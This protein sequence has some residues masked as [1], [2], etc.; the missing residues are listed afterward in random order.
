MDK[1]QEAAQSGWLAVWRDFWRKAERAALLTGLA[2]LAS[3]LVNT[4][5]FDV[6]G[7]NFL[8]IAAPA[9]VLMSGLQVATMPAL[10]AGGYA[11][12]FIWIASRRSKLVAVIAF[13]AALI[14][15]WL[16]GWPI[17]YGPRVLRTWWLVALLGWLIGAGVA[18]F[19]DQ[20]WR[21]PRAPGSGLGARLTELAHEGVRRFVYGGVGLIYL[22]FSGAMVWAVSEVGYSN[23]PVRLA[24]DE[25]LE[26]CVGRVVWTGDRAI[27]VDCGRPPAHDVQV[28]YATD[29]FRVIRDNREWPNPALPPLL[30][31]VGSWLRAQPA[32][33]EVM[34]PAGQGQKPAAR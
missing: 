4:L 9:D 25:K 31:D 30:V 18:L 21:A 1:S 6:W 20:R 33:Q 29:T 27:L 12:G 15:L 13:F 2:F 7:Q 32:V 8:L 16:V 11:V 24:P 10:M 5:I 23:Q 28:F 19:F 22:F 3:T 17:G 14:V 26:G 34:A